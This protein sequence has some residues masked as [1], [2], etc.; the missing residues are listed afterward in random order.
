MIYEILQGIG[1]PVAYGVMRSGQ[2]PPY[3]S[4]RGN[5]QETMAADDTYVWTHNSYVIE[6]YFKLKNEETEASI[7]Q[8]LMNAGFLY[9]KS[10]DIYLEEDG[11]WMIYYYC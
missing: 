7:E 11:V 8:A 6:Y 4:Y 3:L 2:K 5:G 10:E 9:E 1:L